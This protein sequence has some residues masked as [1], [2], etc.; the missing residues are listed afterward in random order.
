M[1]HHGD[2]KPFY[3]THGYRLVSSVFGTLLV[4]GGVYVLLTASPMT[5]SELIGGTALAILGANHLLSAC[6]GKEPWLSKFGP[7]P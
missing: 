7:L 1:R 3:T 5:E 2:S 6:A 4:G